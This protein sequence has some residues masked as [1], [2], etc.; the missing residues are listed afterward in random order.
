MITLLSALF[1]CHFLADFTPLSTTWMLQAKRVGLPLLPIM[2]HG[3]VHAWLQFLMVIIVLTWQN[4]GDFASSHYI[5][6]A[7]IVGIIQF[8]VHTYA[9]VAKGRLQ[10]LNP[11]VLN[12]PANVWHWALFGADQLVHALTIIAEVAFL[13]KHLSQL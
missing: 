9:D 4:P 11:L 7:G 8:I 6:L 5:Q 10:A 13:Q 3:F 2:A 1:F 12:N